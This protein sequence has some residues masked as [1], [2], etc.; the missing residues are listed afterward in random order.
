MGPRR[1]VLAITIVA[2]LAADRGR[3]PAECASVREGSVYVGESV[4]ILTDPGIEAEAVRRAV[5]FWR[6]CPRYGLDFPSF[7]LG[8]IGTRTIRV[9]DGGRNV[10]SARCGSFNGATITLYRFAVSPNGR[11]VFCGPLALNLAHELGH[12]LGL[13]HPNG[14]AQCSGDIMAR[15]NG[16]NAKGRR[17]SPEECRVVGEKWRTPL[18]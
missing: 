10:S 5:E 11:R 1:G 18:E 13:Q 7:V 3:L 8:G 16:I 17:V 12:V 4:G 14:G 9:E 2:S 6:A 15:I